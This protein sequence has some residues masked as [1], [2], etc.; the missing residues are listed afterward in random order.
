MSEVLLTP[1]P[2]PISHLD[3]D[4][5]IAARAPSQSTEFFNSLYVEGVR[6]YTKPLQVKKK[7]M[8]TG[9]AGKLLLSRPQ[10]SAHEQHE[11]DRPQSLHRR[12][13]P[14]SAFP[15]HYHQ[16]SHRQT[17]ISRSRTYS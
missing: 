8:V 16:R 14:L 17:L 11:P 6:G 4:I 1:V 5:K 15:N 12:H 7:A 10:K 13:P 2:E 3:P 9:G